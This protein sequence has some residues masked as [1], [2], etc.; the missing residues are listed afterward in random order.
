M[1]YFHW[2][3][4]GIFHGMF[5]SYDDMVGFNGDMV[6]LFMVFHRITM[7]FM[8]ILYHGIFSMGMFHQCEF[9]V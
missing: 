7:N 2:D 1:G 8:G 6:R 3:T 9:M 4:I 5:L